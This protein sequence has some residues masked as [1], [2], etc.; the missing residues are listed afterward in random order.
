MGEIP[1]AIFQA[2]YSNEECTFPYRSQPHTWGMT[3]LFRALSLTVHWVSNVELRQTFS[4]LTSACSWKFA[5]CWHILCLFTGTDTSG[6]SNHHIRQ[7][8]N[9]KVCQ[10]W[11]TTINCALI[12][13]I[14]GLYCWVKCPDSLG[15]AQR[16]S[17]HA[18]CIGLCKRHKWALNDFL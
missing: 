16:S 7:S 18:V 8:S 15:V 5:V 12:W 11:T 6:E 9:E 4:I 14:K 2:T 17:P 10:S 13:K 1:T 3:L